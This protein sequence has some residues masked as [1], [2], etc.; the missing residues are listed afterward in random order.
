MSSNMPHVEQ[1]VFSAN[2]N[3]NSI[4]LNYQLPL[5]GGEFFSF[6]HKFIV[7]DTHYDP[8]PSTCHGWK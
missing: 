8:I 1:H 5:V 6:H 7:C 4:E 3:A 2:L